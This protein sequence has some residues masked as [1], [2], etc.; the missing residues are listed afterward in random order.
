MR[1]WTRKYHCQSRNGAPDPAEL[2]G[3]TEGTGFSVKNAG[4]RF[5]TRGFSSTYIYDTIVD[6]Q[7][8]LR[9]KKHYFRGG[10]NAL[11]KN[12]KE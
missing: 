10:I 1:F 8:V 5:L 2:N 6:A 12:R 11:L 3:K 9:G 4:V 7:M